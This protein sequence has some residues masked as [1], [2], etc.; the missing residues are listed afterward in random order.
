MKMI[1]STNMMS[2]IGVTLISELRPPPPPDAIPMIKNSFQT[3][4]RDSRRARSLTGTRARSSLT[5]LLLRVQL[6]RAVL[7]EVIDQLRSGV[8]HLHNEAINF[9]R[10]VVEEPDRR[11]CHDETKSGRN[12][13][14]RNTARD[15]RDT[16]RLCIL[17]ALECV[18]DAVYCSEESDERSGRTDCR[19]PR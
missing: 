10:K 5:S 2:T 7:D 18:K 9:A 11:N 14:L 17:H 15:R 8:V 13:R 12:E 19:K 1:R 6:P 3:C 16:C 4:S